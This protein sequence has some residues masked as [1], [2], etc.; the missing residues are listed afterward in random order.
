VPGGGLSP[1]FI[2]DPRGEE[3]LATLKALLDEVN[4]E[5]KRGV[6]AVFRGVQAPLARPGHLS[7]LER[8]NYD[9]AR[10]L[11]RRLADPDALVVPDAGEV[12]Y[13]LR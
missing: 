5:D 1:E 8:P 12:L 13:R 9:F 3:Y 4:A 7:H 10:Y 6:E 11:A 2:R